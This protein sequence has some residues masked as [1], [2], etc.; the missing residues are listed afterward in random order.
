[1]KIAVISLLFV[2]IIISSFLFLNKNTHHHSD[3]KV[4]NDLLTDEEFSIEIFSSENA[5]YGYK[6][7]FQERPLIIQPNIPA[8]PGNDGF[9]KSDDANIVAVYVIEKIKSGEFPPAVTVA[10]LDSLGVL[11]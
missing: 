4:F 1:M 6:I 2:G 11:N 5:T 7:I 3:P 8:L 9:V 10:E